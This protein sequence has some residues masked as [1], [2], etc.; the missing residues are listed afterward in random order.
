MCGWFSGQVTG[1]STSGQRLAALLYVDQG[2]DSLFRG[3]VRPA[4]L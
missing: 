2:A 3:V 1:S 4:K